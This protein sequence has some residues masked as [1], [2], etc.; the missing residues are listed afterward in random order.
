[1][2]DITAY[3]ELIISYT[4]QKKNEIKFLHY[5]HSQTGENKTEI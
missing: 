5:L 2:C 3:S 1:M 4:Q